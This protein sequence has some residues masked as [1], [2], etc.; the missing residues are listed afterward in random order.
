MTGKI[1]EIKYGVFI[2][3]QDYNANV[4]VTG[5][6]SSLL[7]GEHPLLSKQNLFINSNQ[8]TINPDTNVMTES[9][10]QQ[11]QAESN[12]VS[13]ESVAIP[14]DSTSELIVDANNLS[15]SLE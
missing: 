15:K 3:N 12:I 4:K 11:P 1:D 7:E 13:N 10:P 14:E 9:S 2:T 6:S 5:V 8:E